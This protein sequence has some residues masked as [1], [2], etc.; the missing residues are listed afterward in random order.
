MPELMTA[1]IEHYQ[2]EEISGEKAL[3]EKYSADVPVRRVENI[4]EAL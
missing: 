2:R 4:T 1:I 3:V